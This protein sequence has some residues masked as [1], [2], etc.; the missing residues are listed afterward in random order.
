MLC[1]SLLWS[2][3]FTGKN[4]LTLEEAKQSEEEASKM[5]EAI[6]EPVKKAIL[7]MIHSSQRV[8]TWQLFDEV[9]SIIKDRYYVGEQVEAALEKKF[10]K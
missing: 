4:S 9:W 5:I 1:K 7:S 8:S 2:C 6:P 3:E 10:V